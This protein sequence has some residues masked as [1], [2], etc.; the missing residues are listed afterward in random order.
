MFTVPGVDGYRFLMAVTRE[1]D[2]SMRGDVAYRA[3]INDFA[4]G[5]NM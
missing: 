3:C 5:M 2:K 4:S 1:V